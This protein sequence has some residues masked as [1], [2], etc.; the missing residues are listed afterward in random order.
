MASYINIKIASKH[1]CRWYEFQL[2]IKKM[3][4]RDWENDSVGRSTYCSRL[5]PSTRVTR[6][7][8]AHPSPQCC[9]E[10]RENKWNLSAGNQAPGLRERERACFKGHL[11]SFSSLCTHICGPELLCTLMQLHHS[12]SYS[13]TKESAGKPRTTNRQ[14][15]W[16]FPKG[17]RV[18]WHAPLIPS[19]WR[20]EQKD[21]EFEIIVHDIA[22]SSPA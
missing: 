6:W 15:G 14:R 19:P 20:W 11:T 13:H 17:S 4:H 10:R 5:I 2:P 7:V 9:E 12:Y 1:Q 18:W 16:S 3:V 8:Q 21:R 22:S